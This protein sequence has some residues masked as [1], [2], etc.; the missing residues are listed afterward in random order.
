MV[1]KAY[2]A[3]S[4]RFDLKM[5]GTNKAPKFPMPSNWIFLCRYYFLSGNEEALQQL[6]LTLNK[7]ALGGIYDQTGGGFARYSTDAEWFAPHFEKMLY[8]NGQLLSLYSEAYTLTRDSLYKNV[9]T[10]TLNWLEREMMDKQGGFYSALDADSEGEEGK[11]YVWEYEELEKILGEDTAL[12]F[13]YYNVKKNG[14]WEKNYNI[15]Y[16]DLSDKAFANKHK[17]NEEEFAEKVESWK[18]ILLEQRNKRPRPGLDDKILASWN[19]IVL[20]GLT[21]AYKALG[22]ERILLMA[23]KNA[24]FIQSKMLKDGRLFHSWKNGKASIEGF[25]EDYSFVIEA[26]IGLYECNFDESWL[27]LA[28]ELTEIVLRDFFDSEEK[29]FYFTSAKGEKLIA[30]K[31]DMFDN[32][33]PSSNSCMALNLFRIGVVFEN[34]E[35]QEISKAM[36][37]KVLKMV[38]TDLGYTSNWAILLCNLV[39]PFTEV[40]I[41]GS[42]FKEFS[43]KLY[44]DFYYPTKVVNASADESSLPLL[45]NRE[46]KE[47]KT[48]VYVCFNKMCNLPVETV[49]K[50]K[51]QMLTGIR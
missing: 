44:S 50:A 20:K 30:R 23:E 48:M 15:L 13:D 5:G 46:P 26:F 18:T 7:M 42:A 43:K 28:K 17:L 24:R 32:V 1:E 2:A 35:Y 49:E 10:E 45:Q 25:L 8:D 19:G 27:M 37:A 39:R 38:V 14:N 33:I 47:G 3:F 9:I 29:F 40:V 41:S 11:F 51:K 21:D 31:K 6:K 12:F 4:N 16:R 36:L 34:V 22:D